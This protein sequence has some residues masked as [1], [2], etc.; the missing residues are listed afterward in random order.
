MYKGK[1]DPLECKSNRGIS[2]LSVP[3]KLYGRILID[4]VVEQS[5]GQI[6]EEQS[7]FRKGRSC[8]DQ[9]FVLRQLCEKMKEKGKKVW[10]AFMDLEKAYDRV[11]REALWQV[12]RIYGIGGRVLRGIMS[13][14]VEGRACVRVGGEISES[15]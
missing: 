8:S 7:G 12:L 9:I 13:F 14:Y 1:G 15:F 6:G 2:L 4:R 3:G 10:I 11:D 5:E